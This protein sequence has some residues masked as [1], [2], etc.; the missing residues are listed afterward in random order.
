VS[1]KAALASVA[2]FL[3]VWAPYL[4]LMARWPVDGWLLDSLTAATLLASFA[5]GIASG[6]YVDTRRKE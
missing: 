2:A 4:L 3:A 5:A 1:G 6:A